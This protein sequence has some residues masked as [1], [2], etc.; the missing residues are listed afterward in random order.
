V[1][2]HSAVASRALPLLLA[3]NKSDVPKAHSVDFIRKRLEGQIEQM[4]GTRGTLGDDGAA[5][6]AAA[7][8][9]PGQAFTFAALGAAGPGPRIE[10]ASASALEAGGV[11]DVES[12]IRRC[13]RS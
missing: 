9:A 4:R 1:L 13:M 5:A 8:G 2:S 6:A 11:A 10:L 3:C 7:L 12:F